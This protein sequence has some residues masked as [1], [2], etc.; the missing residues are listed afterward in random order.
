[1]QKI[2]LDA[3]FTCPNR[4]GSKGTGGCSFCNNNAF[5][6]SYCT[7]EKSISQQIMEGI[8]FHRRRYR[9][10]NKF[11]AYFQAYTNTYAPLNQLKRLYEEA[12]EF[13]EIAGLV[14]GT[15]PD[16]ADEEILNY[17][18][19]LNNRTYLVVEYGIESCYDDTLTRINRGHDYAATVRAINNTSKRGIRTGGHIII[20]LPGES[21]D[22]ILKSAEILSTL[23]LSNIK[24]HQLQ[25]VRDTRI[26]GEYLQNPALFHDYSTDE[27]IELIIDIIER[28]NPSFLLERIAGETPP[29]YNIRPSWKLR[30]D[31]ILQRFEKRLEERDTW[32]GK[33]YKT[34]EINK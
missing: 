23:P 25:I 34:T 6:P 10:V 14:I 15:R 11:L 28:L 20:G 17:L 4:D 21:R 13:P 12:I 8:E 2:S 33:Y 19:E 27:Y 26:A 1:M 3:G 16:C 18:E 9:R 24:F 31:Q 5:N 32:Q 30:Y 22:D 7:P 29:D